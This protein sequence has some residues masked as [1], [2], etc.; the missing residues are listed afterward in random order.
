MVLLLLYSLAFILP[1]LAYGAP[2]TV[3]L[4]LATVTGIES[5][6][7][8]KFLG[9]PFGEA[10][11]FHLPL[12]VPPYVASIDATAYGPSCPQQLLSPNPLFPPGTSPTYES[13]DCLSVNVLRPNG[14][15]VSSKLPVAV[16]IYGGGFEVGSSEQYD[17]LNTRMV[18][19]SIA[20]GKPLVL[21]SVNYRISAYGFLA[22]KEI[23]KEGLGN[24]GLY[25]QRLG[26]WWIH[27]YISAFGGDPSKVTIWG[28]SAGGISV[29]L[30][31]LAFGGDSERL[32]RGAFMQSGGPMS[33]YYDELVRDAGCSSS[34]NSLQCLRK[35]PFATLKNAVDKSPDFFSYDGIPLAWTPRID[36]VFLQDHPQKLIK[37]KKVADVPFVTGNM[38]DEGTLFA[39]TQSN[40]TTEEGFRTYIR[41]LYFQGASETE[42]EGVWKYYTSIPSEGSPFGTGDLN[43][44]YPQYKRIAA[45]LG[46]LIFHSPRRFFLDEVSG[47]QK[48][49]SY[50]SMIQ[51]S[52]P[53][54]GACHGVDLSSPFLDDHFVNFVANLDPNSG[55]GPLWPQYTVASPM[56]YKFIDAAAPVTAPDSYRINPIQYLINLALKYPM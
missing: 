45:F 51:K 28:E 54:L 32:F 56:L 11:R 30:H 24:I 42:L 31:M 46:D 18:E 4:D 6:N 47:K 48:T 41:Q 2:P 53:M 29:A 26:L 22:G 5:G 21:V 40:L 27:K 39:F 13:E 33:K 25:D 10:P 8:T 52:T 14:V 38:D 23:E 1:C 43:Q 19:R 20:L 3:Y 55:S 17:A 34:H 44:V 9:I 35:V 50:L 36:G 12:P 7:I 49:W 37:A 16:W 15:N